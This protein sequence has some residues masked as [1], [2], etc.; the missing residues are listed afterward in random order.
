[1]NKIK[2]FGIIAIIAIVG[3]SLMSCG[4]EKGGSLIIENKTG[5]TITA[6][7][8]EGSTAPTSNPTPKEVKNTE[9]VTLISISE[10]GKV[11]YSWWY[12]DNTIGKF[13]TIDLKGGKDTNIIADK[14]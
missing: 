10:N 2:L 8:V 1:M 3:L 11:Y 13:N 5:D 6:W 4:G 14:K 7:A 12:S 9:K